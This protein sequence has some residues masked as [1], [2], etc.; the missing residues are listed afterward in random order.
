MAS[1]IRVVSHD[2]FEFN[3][4]FFE[5]ICFRLDPMAEILFIVVGYDC[6]NSRHSLRSFCDPESALNFLDD[7]KECLRLANIV[8][9]TDSCSS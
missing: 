8:D 6:F 2:G 1:P 4:S 7:L 9:A 5:C 3:C